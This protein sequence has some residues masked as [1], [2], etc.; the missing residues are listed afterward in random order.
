MKHYS[1]LKKEVIEGLNINPDGIYVDG[2]L[3]YG[4]HSEEIL[5]R[6]RRGFL[7]AF[8]QD[9]EAIH[10]GQKRLSKVSDNFKIIYSNFSYLK[11]KLELENTKQVDGI[12]LDLGL[13]SPQIDNEKR[14]F[15]FMKDA[16]LDMRMDKQNKL[17]A[18]T[19]VNT[20][21]LSDLTKIFYQYGEERFSSSIA[22]NI[23]KYRENKNIETTKEL[24]KIIKTSV[25]VK[26]FIE[27]HPERKIFQAIRIEVNKE[28]E[29]LEKV[30]NDAILLLKPK[31]RICV[32]SFHSLE[33]RIVKQI[34]KKNSEI[35]KLVKGLPEIPD[36]YLPLVKLIN[37]KPIIATLGELQENSRSKSAKLR[38]IERI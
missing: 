5:K 38:I 21:C 7:F 6:L 2:T 20:Y 29:V 34:F 28:L 4:G 15:T 13:S 24:V 14:G 18:K 27:K 31:G 1:V 26:Y 35:N 10:F 12:I 19:I 37:K 25:P 3:G 32:I 17:T 36:E 16:P 23:V 9:E 30:L 8:D 33:D 22:K 11:E